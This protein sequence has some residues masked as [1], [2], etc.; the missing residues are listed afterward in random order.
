[1]YMMNRARAIT[2]AM[3]VNCNHSMLT[4]RFYR[5]LKALLSLFMERLKYV[6]AINLMPAL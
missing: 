2:Q 6:I 4:Y 3:F 5:Q 1:M